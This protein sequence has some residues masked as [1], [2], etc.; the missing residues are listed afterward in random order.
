MSRA[1]MVVQTIEQARSVM[2]LRKIISPYELQRAQL[3]V[4]FLMPGV[5]LD[6]SA[7]AALNLTV[8]DQLR[9]RTLQDEGSAYAGV[10][11]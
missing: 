5:S 9:E 6:F 1:F 10:A 3:R 2:E 8:V 11:P 4:M 7:R